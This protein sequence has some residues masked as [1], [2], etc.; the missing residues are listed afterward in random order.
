MYAGKD[1]QAKNFTKKWK[2][3]IDIAKAYLEKSS[4][5]TKKGPTL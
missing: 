3:T 4:K 2:Q 5:L 1:F